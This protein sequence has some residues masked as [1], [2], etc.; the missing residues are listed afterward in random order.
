MYLI[1]VAAVLLLV[2]YLCK[3]VFFSSTPFML[4][5]GSYFLSGNDQSNIH[6][7]TDTSQSLQEVLNA[8]SAGKSSIFVMFSANWCGPC[9]ASKPKFLEAAS[10]HPAKAVANIIFLEPS[11]E[12][13]THG[14]LN[15]FKEANV[16]GFPTFKK[17]D[18]VGNQW[19][20]ST[21][22]PKERSTESIS[23]WM[24]E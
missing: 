24:S 20:A 17:Y 15:L 19:E 4:A 22:T 16:K 1:L 10:K 21:S 8:A 3:D 7:I 13:S 6:F 12:G 11:E 2:A 5:G 18:K 9:Q 14:T 23:A